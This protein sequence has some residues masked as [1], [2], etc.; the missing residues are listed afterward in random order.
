[1]TEKPLPLGMMIDTPTPWDSLETWERHLTEVQALPSFVLQE[2][3]AQRAQRI[4]SVKKCGRAADIG[5]LRM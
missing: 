5:A 3:I 2:E 1:M 4:I